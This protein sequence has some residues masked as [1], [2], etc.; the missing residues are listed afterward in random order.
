MNNQD[1]KK[2]SD[3]ISNKTSKVLPKILKEYVV[4]NWSHISDLKNIG[5]LEIYNKLER[6]K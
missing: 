5:D 3:I 1:N 4:K 2:L 6:N